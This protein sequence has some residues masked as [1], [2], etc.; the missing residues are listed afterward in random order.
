MNIYVYVVAAPRAF[1]FVRPDAYMESRFRDVAVCKIQRKSIESSSDY[2]VPSV[3]V[4]V[5]YILK[6]GEGVQ[7]LFTACARFGST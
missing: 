2:R 4:C 5:C 6:C 1:P 7:L 3:Y